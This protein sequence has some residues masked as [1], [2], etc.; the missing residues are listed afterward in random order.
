MYEFG[1]FRLDAAKRTLLRGQTPVALTPKAFDTLLLLVQ[2]R[3]RV[4]LKDELMRSVWPES[5]VEESNLSQTIFVLRKIFGET[6]QDQRYIVTVRG[7]GYRFAE[8]VRELPPQLLQELNVDDPVP[9]PPAPAPTPSHPWRVIAVVILVLVG[10]LVAAGVYYRS[11]QRAKLTEKDIVVLAEFDNR[12]GDPIFDGTLKPAL[13]MDLEQTP[14]LSLL[15]DR[16]VRATLKLMNRPESDPVTRDVSL[17]ICERT[18]SRAVIAGS[19]VSIG[20][21]YSLS[22]DALDCRQNGA[23]IATRQARAQNKETVLDALS[24]AAAALRRDLGESLAS[25]RKFDVPLREA[26]TPSLEALKSFNAGAELTR[27]APDPSAAI[28]FYTHAIE[29]DP[30]FALAYAYLGRVYCNIGEYH[31]AIPYIEKAYSLR[32]RVS[33]R[34]KLLLT[35]FYASDVL[36][37]SDKEVET[38]KIWMEEYPRDWIPVDSLATVYASYFNESGKAVELYQRAMQLDPQQSYSRV[39]LARSYLALGKVQDA[40][41]VL[42]T[43][44]AAGDENWM[45][46]APLFEVSTLQGDLKT[47]G[48]QVQWSDRQPAQDNIN[49]VIV[50]AALQQGRFKEAQARVKRDVQDLQAAG[51]TDSAA[52]EYA[53]LALTEASFLL[54]KETRRHAASSLALSRK[55][56][57]L[58]LS[59]ALALSGDPAGAETLAREFENAP[60]NAFHRRFT[61]PCVRAA[62]AISRRNFD[63]AISLLEPMRRYDQAPVTGFQSLYLRGLA[64]LGKQDAAKAAAEFQTIVEH[65]G[66]APSNPIWAL[67]HLQLARARRQ[68]GDRIGARE[69]YATLFN[70]WRDADRSLPLLRQAQAEQLQTAPTKETQIVPSR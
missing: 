14:F 36:G 39:G 50:S 17:E 19:I 47:A 49:F 43:A 42:D 24:Q 6:A 9:S 37:D 5:F 52:D 4:L 32:D 63:D 12:T 35:S 59:M 31:R 55:S 46:R 21:K 68:T 40:R 29:L 30:E 48:E 18:G 34:E 22:L 25:I 8:P 51:L 1:P 65:R 15:P 58:V 56:N 70:L 64:F 60:P 41:S 45:V 69:A 57:L 3:D 11:R 38:Y 16:R 53:Q 66:I 67:A 26:T 7:T 44:L 13:T 20:G 27:H 10:L 62:I 23:V 61:I 33:E 54:S 2:N 28:P